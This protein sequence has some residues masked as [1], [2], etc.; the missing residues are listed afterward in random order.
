[1]KKALIALAIL[2]ASPVVART[3]GRPSG[4]W[5]PETDIKELHVQIQKV[6]QKRDDWQ[7]QM[8]QFK[9]ALNRLGFNEDERCIHGGPF[10]CLITRSKPKNSSF[11]VKVSVAFPDIPQSTLISILMVTIYDAEG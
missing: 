9:S 10:S 2:A 4:V 7:T 11:M 8:D 5:N 1:M 6:Q 3:D